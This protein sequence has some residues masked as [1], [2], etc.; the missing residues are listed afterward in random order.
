[1][2]CRCSTDRQAAGDEHLAGALPV[3]LIHYIWCKEVKGERMESNQTGCYAPVTMWLDFGKIKRLAWA[4]EC[5][6]THLLVAG[7]YIITC[8]CGQKAGFSVGNPVYE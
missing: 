6:R 3:S 1:M 7:K 5:G 8:S 2:R 4:C